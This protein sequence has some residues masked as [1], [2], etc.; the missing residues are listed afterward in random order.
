[1]AV[2]FTGL[3]GAI[4]GRIRR[5]GEADTE[6]AAGYADMPGDEDAAALRRDQA[7]AVMLL[8]LLLT[9]TPAFAAFVRARTDLDELVLPLLRRVHVAL[10]ASVVQ[11]RPEHIDLMLVLVLILSRDVTVRESLRSHTLRVVPWYREQLLVDVCVADLVVI[12][13]AR[14]AAASVRNNKV[15]PTR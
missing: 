1:M 5:A 3:Y 15:M 6:M 14:V 8:Y 13:L 12:V 9:S 11:D 10:H 7:G 2:S 4:V